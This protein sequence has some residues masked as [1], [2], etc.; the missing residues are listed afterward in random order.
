MRRRPF[1][2]SFALFVFA[3]SAIAALGFPFAWNGAD[4]VISPA[5]DFFGIPKA[6]P[7]VSAQVLAPTAGFTPGNLV[8]C[9]IGDGVSALT[10]SATA[11]FLDEYTT[12]GILVQSVA[13]PTTL[14]GSNLPLTLSGNATSECQ[15]S[16]SPD[17]KYVIVTGYGALLGT[18]TVSS[19]AGPRVIGRVDA[20]G[21]ID[22]SSSTTSFGTSNIR[23]ATTTDGSGF[24]SVGSSAG[25]VFVAL[26]A[27]DVGTIVSNT[28]TNNRVVH[29]YGGQL[30]TSDASGTTVR[31]G[32]VGTGTPTTT[33]NAIT[34][35]PGFPATGGSPDSFFLADLNG[36]V[37]G[38]D[39]LYVAD[40]GSAGLLSTSG[41]VKKFSLVGGS[42]V[43]NGIFPASGSPSIPAAGFFGLT[44]K[45]VAGTVTLYATRG[46]TANQLVQF[47]DSTGY[48]VAPTA[49]PTLLATAGTN[50]VIRS[51]AL[52]P[53]PPPGINLQGFVGSPG[54]FVEHC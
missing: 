45:V 48:N 13:M 6:E 21:A 53:V 32:S 23:G 29:I 2:Y 7:K 35:L 49:V 36:G 46:T 17:G 11:V 28:V 37:P 43:F 16:R 15:L 41:G 38:V 31:I 30:Y 1:S 40:D 10:S 5:R 8:V 44:G 26:G 27:S 25:V 3:I 50:T 9:R 39:T 51:V 24:W 22:T 12:G 20:T 47:V 14:S 52:A 34:N 54:S 4:T 33:G 42:W 18:A 19:A